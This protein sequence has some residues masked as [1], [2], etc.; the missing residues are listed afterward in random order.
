MKL[1]TYG[2]GKKTKPGIISTD[3]E[4]VFPLE[5]FDMG[6]MDM[7]DLI[8]NISSSEQQLLEYASGKDP[9]SIRGAVRIQEVQLQ[10]PIEQPEQDIICLGVNYMDHAEES[11]RFRGREFNGKR[12]DA[13][14]FSKR[15]NKAIGDQAVIPAH[16]D[17][18]DSLDYEA[19]LA[20]IIG[21]DASHV[22]PDQVKDYIF[23]YTILNDVS[24]RNIQTRHKQWYF[25]KS[26][27]GFAPMGP[28]I[29][30][31]DKVDYPP[32]LTI[33]S[34]VNGELRQDSNTQL[35]IFNIDHVI[36]ELSGGM[37]LK[38]GTIISTGTPAGV[39]LG[40]DPP[41]YLKSGDV[42]TCAVEGIGKITN[43]V[44]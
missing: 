36:S 43:R 21:K 20:V 1:V 22:T 37:T 5:A 34:Y 40:F 12:P 24:A 23:G 27:D 44:Q 19:E 17:I 42:V 41:K 15:V 25:G 35:L 26:L 39:G 2:I 9:E 28:C 33:Q 4:W 31:A 7:L 11:S 13:I 6:Y 32:H 3:E 29:L 16:V 18:V 8:K 38:A 30:T 14:Y 10:A